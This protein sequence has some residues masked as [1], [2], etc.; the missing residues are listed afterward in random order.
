MPHSAARYRV[1]VLRVLELRDFVLAE[2]VRLEVSE[3]LNVL[4]GETGAGKSLLVD[5][6]GLLTGVR[7]EAGL[8]RHG[9]KRALVQADFDHRSASRSLVQEG[10]NVAR[11]DGEIVTVAELS[12]LVGTDVA[13]FAQH[14]QQALLSA[15]AQRAALDRM[16]DPGGQQTLAQWRSVWKERSRLEQAIAELK[17]ATESRRQR[18]ALLAHH[19]EEIDAAELTVDEELDLSA[20]ALRLR[21]ADQILKSVAASHAALDGDEGAVDRLA[22]AHRALRE[23]KELDPRFAALSEDLA[24]TLRSTQAIAAELDSSLDPSAEEEGNLN[25]IEARIAQ[26]QRLFAKYGDGTRGVLAY[27]DEIAGELSAL[28]DSAEGVAALE[29]ELATCEAELQKM[30]PV[31]RDARRAAA[32]QLESGV[33]PILARLAM[34]SAVLTV[35]VRDARFGAHGADSVEFTFV[36]NEG[37][38][39]APLAQAASGGELSRVML[40]LWLITGSDRSTLVFDEVDAGVGGQAA[41]AVGALL[42]ELAERHQV[43]VVTHLAQ[44]AAHAHHHV[45]VG[46]ATRD[47]RTITSV[48]SLAGEERERELARM[49]AGHDGDTAMA[50]ARDLLERA[51]RHA[52]F[53]S[54]N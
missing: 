1:A 12:E 6:L 51:G 5:A 44:V 4:T 11:I 2:N 54:P 40:A 27:R 42:A 24:A 33:G 45:H 32:R 35:N 18:E 22:A 10:R 26:L 48:R 37:E 28:R 13:V 53:P 16:L 36:A 39:P 47:G 52:D 19:L 50:A 41:A 34:P 25:Q 21:H 43:L 20:R 31:L 17:A 30:A 23:A 9:A 29:R 3:G 38:R 46:K 7:A 49:L 14:A 15:S 8:I